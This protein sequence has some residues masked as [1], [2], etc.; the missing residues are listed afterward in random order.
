MNETDLLAKGFIQSKNGSWSKPVHQAG[1]LAPSSVM[2]SN[3]NI[4][5]VAKDAREAPDA[6]RRLVR[7]TL[8]RVRTVDEENW[9]TKHFTDALILSR[10]LFDDSPRWCK[11]E[12]TQVKVRFP[13]EERTEIEIVPLDEAD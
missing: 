8:F 9:C 6:V 3:P 4:Q 2:E 13:S 11:I 7:Y 10:L 5:S 1:R 12:V